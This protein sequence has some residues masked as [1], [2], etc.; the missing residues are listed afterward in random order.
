MRLPAPLF[1]LVARGV[2]VLA[3]LLLGDVLPVS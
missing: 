2:S 1:L 3:G